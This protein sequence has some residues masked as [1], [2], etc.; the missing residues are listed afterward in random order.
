MGLDSVEMVIG[1]EQRFG[2][3]IPNEVAC[4]LVTPR[5]ATDYIFLQMQQ[6][7]ATECIRQQTFFRLR[8]GF[9][10][11]CPGIPITF[12]PAT[13]LRE[14][15]SRLHWPRIWSVVRAEDPGRT[16]PEQAPLQGR[17]TYRFRTVGDLVQ[18]LALGDPRAT[19]QP[20]GAWTREQVSL[21]VRRVMGRTIGAT[22]FDE[23]AHFV[24]DLGIQ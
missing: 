2:I 22:F 8:R 5:L 18:E 7:P 21:Q 24:R 11:A 4:G 13:K 17:F 12:A 10:R 6:R 20:E 19:G 9:R 15:A 16:W 1:W 23:D 14:L 3:L